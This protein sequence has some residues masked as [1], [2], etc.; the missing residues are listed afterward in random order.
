MTGTLSGK[1]TTFRQTNQMS[2]CQKGCSKEGF[3]T[4]HL[5]DHNRPRKKK[6]RETPAKKPTIEKYPQLDHGESPKKEK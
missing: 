6:G 3:D 2:R 4:K 1:K 5:V